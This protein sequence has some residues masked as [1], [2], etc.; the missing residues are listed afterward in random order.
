MSPIKISILFFVLLTCNVAIFVHAQVNA[1]LDQPFITREGTAYRDKLTIASS[2]SVAQF[3]KQ[4]QRRENGKVMSYQCLFGHDRLTSTVIST[5]II[6]VNI[7]LSRQ[8]ITDDKLKSGVPTSF[9]HQRSQ[10]LE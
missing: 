2:R 8:H 1:E 9:K 5:F 4:Y 3:A 10:H 7:P 6:N